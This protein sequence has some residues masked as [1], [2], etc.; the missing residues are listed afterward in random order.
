VKERPILFSSPMVRAILDGSKTQTR[1]VVK[2]A[3]GAFWDHAG[4][5]PVIV[6][7][8]V[9]WE[10]ADTG[11]RLH[12]PML[13]PRPPCPFGV[14]GDRLWVR[15]TWCDTMHRDPGAEPERF[16]DGRV[17]GVEYR[18]SHSCLSFE[19]GCPCNPDGNSK[20][21]EWRPSIHMPRWASRI[22]LE[23]TDVR[24]ERL[25]AI[26]EEDARAEGVKRDTEPCDH[27]RRA[28]AD[29][30]CMGPT[31]KSTFCEL[32]DSLNAKRAPWASNP[33]VWAIS[34]KRVTA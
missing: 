15:E 1:R 5:R 21:S 30:E 22:T 24:V 4:W 12:D 6:D 9:R 14:P 2:D 3:T 29:I 20:R 13:A 34:F 11:R 25:Q 23:I 33:W 19:D 31:F 18:A 27:I 17:E 26:S 8:C 28:C 16:I 10:D 7:G 32:W